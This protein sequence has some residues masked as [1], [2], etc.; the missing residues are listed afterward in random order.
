MAGFS[1]ISSPPISSN[2]PPITGKLLLSFYYTHML[3]QY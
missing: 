3:R 1:P 2:R